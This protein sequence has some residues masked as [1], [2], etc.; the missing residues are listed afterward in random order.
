MTDGKITRWRVADGPARHREG[1]YEV[2]WPA[3]QGRLNIATF[4]GPNAEQLSIE[5]E[6]SLMR[7]DWREGHVQDEIDDDIEDLLS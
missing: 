6:R 5:Y 1:A 7:I 3:G 4:S 2:A